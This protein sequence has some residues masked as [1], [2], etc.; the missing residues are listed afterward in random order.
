MEYPNFQYFGISGKR[1]DLIVPEELKVALLAF[2]WNPSDRSIC[3]S[4]HDGWKCCRNE[5]TTGPHIASTGD[6]CCAAW[7]YTVT[8][9]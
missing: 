5:H 1:Y 2:E 4:K 6:H 3:S 9:A 8:P 7:P